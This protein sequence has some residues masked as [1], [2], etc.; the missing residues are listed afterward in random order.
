MDSA[1]KRWTSK[2]EK[3]LNEILGIFDVNVS[4]IQHRRN[5]NERLKVLGMNQ[6]EFPDDL[7][8]IAGDTLGGTVHTLEAPPKT[9]EKVKNDETDTQPETPPKSYPSSKTYSYDDEYDRHRIC[10][11]CR[12]FTFAG[13]LGTILLG[14]IAIMSITLYQLRNEDTQSN[15]ELNMSGSGSSNSNAAAYDFSD[16]ERN[17]S[18]LS[19]TISNMTADLS[20]EGQ[21][22]LL[23]IQATILS[24]TNDFY[25]ESETM[26]MDPASLHYR[27]LSWLAEDPLLASYSPSRI[28]QRY[29]LGVMYLS[30]TAESKDVTMGGWMTYTDECQWPQSRSSRSM[31]EPSGNV[32]AMNLENMGFDGTLPPEIG[33]LSNLEFLV[34][35]SNSLSG[36]LPTQLGLLTRLRRL[37][38]PGN[39][40]SGTIPTQ[41]G[42]LEN[43]SKCDTFGL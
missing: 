30:L 42:F 40:I 32:T 29:A 35:K 8:T 39:A 12:L 37:N 28:V 16:I 5:P 43:L 25:S 18:T 14:A 38:L 1:L 10:S 2:D 6:P 23:Q 19:P 21:Q 27:V 13:C 26:S 34:L 9:P 20:E 4:P 22:L 15:N 41:I 24:M 31:C 7:S 11:F 33:L 3:S 36:Q 17:S